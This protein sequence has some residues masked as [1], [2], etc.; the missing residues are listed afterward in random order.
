MFRWEKERLS[1]QLLVKATV[2]DERK[3]AADAINAIEI[4]TRSMI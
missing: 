4:Q 2:Q 3:M 1:A